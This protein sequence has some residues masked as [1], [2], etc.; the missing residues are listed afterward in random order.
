MLLSFRAL[1]TLLRCGSTHQT[2]RA[3]TR[4]IC[5]EV[6]IDAFQPRDVPE[7]EA[8]CRHTEGP[9]VGWVRAGDPWH[10]LEN[11]TTAGSEEGGTTTQ[12]R[13]P[14]RLSPPLLWGL[15]V[16]RGFV[17]SWERLF[18]VLTPCRVNA[19]WLAWAYMRIPYAYMH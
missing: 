6:E 10:V 3:I 5:V 13:R 16:V 1:V 17:G 19:H 7:N 18:L 11:L 4:R 9:T 12:R 15:M 2:T 8:P 14:P